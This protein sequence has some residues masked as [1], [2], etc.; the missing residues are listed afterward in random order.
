MRAIVLVLLLALPAP[1]QYVI[2][3]QCPGGCCP[4]GSCGPQYYYTQPAPRHRQAPSP[5]GIETPPVGSPGTP[6]FCPN[7]PLPAPPIATP[8]I[9]PPPSTPPAPTAPISQAKPCDCG[10][11]LD[12]L[13]TAVKDGGCKCDNSKLEASIVA[14]TEAVKN[15]KGCDTSKL[16]QKIDALVA[17]I[18][19]QKPPETSDQPKAEEHVVIVADH[20]APYWQRLAEAINNTKKTYSG[21]QET[22]LPEFAI[23]VHPQAVVYR[24][25]VPVRIAKGQYEVE[26]LLTRLA[27]GEPI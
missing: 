13:I 10:P 7:A 14:L 25:S 15:Q 20:N 19:N 24:N 22:T 16:E 9:P 6:D 4:G 18:Q 8:P 11:K 12:A 5:D 27:R 17:A 2:Y 1:A 3:T 21:I 23:G 26:A